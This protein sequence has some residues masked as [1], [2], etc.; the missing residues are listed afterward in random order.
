MKALS[1]IAVVFL[2][3]VSCATLTEEEEYVR[4][5]AFTLARERFEV[6]L[7]ACNEARGV[8]MIH[9]RATRIKKQYTRSEM[10]FAQCVRW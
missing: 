9:A 3:L 6:R 7:Q 1:I 5:D 10:E 8:M 4:E 2:L